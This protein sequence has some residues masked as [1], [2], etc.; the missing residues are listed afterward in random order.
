MNLFYIFIMNVC[1]VL[2]I[3]GTM[4]YILTP[5]QRSRFM[6]N[7]YK[8]FTY[9]AVPIIFSPFTMKLHVAIESALE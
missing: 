3:C 9:S 6:R 4:K 2:Y 1:Y 7:L 8:S 5:L